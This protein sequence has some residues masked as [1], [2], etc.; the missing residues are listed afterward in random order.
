MSLSPSP[1]SPELKRRSS[2]ASANRSAHAHTATGP[3]AR[4]PLPPSAATKLNSP[5]STS[6]LS[7]KHNQANRPSFATLC[8]SFLAQWKDSGSSSLTKRR[9]KNSAATISFSTASSAAAAMSASAAAAE[10]EA[11]YPPIS[12]GSGSSRSRPPLPLFTRPAA[13]VSETHLP[14]SAISPPTSPLSPAVSDLTD[15]ATLVAAGGLDNQ[16]VSVPIQ[17]SST[18]PRQSPPPPPPTD[19]QQ[20]GTSGGT[21]TTAA[22]SIHTYMSSPHLPTPLLEDSVTLE[23]QLI[24][25]AMLRRT[26]LASAAAA[27]VVEIAVS[28]DGTSPVLQA[29]P[30][31]PTSGETADVANEK[32]LDDT[33]MGLPL[34]AVSTTAVAA[35][36]N[37]SPQQQQQQPIT[38]VLP[39]LPPGATVSVNNKPHQQ[40]QQPI[41]MVLPPLPAGATVTLNNGSPRPALRW[42]DDVRDNNNPRGGGVGV[43]PAVSALKSRPGVTR[44]LSDLRRSLSTLAIKLRSPMN[45]KD[46]DEDEDYDSYYFQDGYFTAMSAGLSPRAT[47][48]AAAEGSSTTTPPTASTLSSSSSPSVQRRR[49]KRLSSAASPTSPTSPTTKRRSRRRSSLSVRNGTG[50]HSVVIKDVSPESVAEALAPGTSYAQGLA[51][52]FDGEK[53]ARD[54]DDDDDEDEEDF[55]ASEL[56]SDDDASSNNASRASTAL[57]IDDGESEE[58]LPPL[59]NPAPRLRRS[60]SE[61]R[62]RTSVVSTA[63]SSVFARWTNYNNNT[64]Q[65]SGRSSVKG[66]LP[67]ASVST[68]SLASNGSKSG[69]SS[70]PWKQL[71]RRLNA[72][73][74]SLA[75]R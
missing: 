33:M 18:Q 36:A 71:W 24:G 61:P 52:L 67:G 43:P 16:P 3:N 69:S 72:S 28:L 75:M 20:S 14:S 51:S 53:Q 6:Q 19:D 30:P 11:F 74:T 1:S 60:R 9:R 39:P 7:T 57:H 22:M 47:A 49:R 10:A 68:S 40:P 17:E 37:V 27:S 55:E 59:S 65:S 23:D 5:S 46:Q 8:R 50:R 70:K 2:R 29:A 63:S 56:E 34:T 21:S 66:L 58:D 41:T 32:T 44:A 73:T 38:M 31:A 26:S 25:L 42:T 15:T 35:D 45:S 4:P 64:K 62:L 13:S 12:R 48:A 54:D